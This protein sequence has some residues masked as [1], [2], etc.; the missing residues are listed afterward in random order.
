MPIVFQWS[1]KTAKGTIQKGDLTANT[2]EEVIAYLRK[3]NIIPTI[4]TQKQK[5]KSALRLPGFGGGVKDKDIVVFTR[6]FAAT[7]IDAGLPLVQALEILGKQTENKKLAQVIGDVKA[8]VEGGSTYADALKKHPK[9]FSDLYANMVAA[10]E[11]GGILDTILN[12][13]AGYIE[14]SMKLKRQVKS[15]MI[16]PSAIVIVAVIV[17]LPKCSQPLAVYCHCLRG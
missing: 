12:R 6:Q 14:K 16:Y 10:G 15:A 4:I 17:I 11:S 9:V 13:L 2:R 1:G 3:Q 7:M 8:D 5:A